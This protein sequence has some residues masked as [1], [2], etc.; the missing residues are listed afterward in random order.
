[1]TSISVTVR[2]IRRFRYKGVY[3]LNNRFGRVELTS[4]SVTVIVSVEG[5]DIKES[6]YIYILNIELLEWDPDFRFRHCDSVRDLFYSCTVFKLCCYTSHL[7]YVLRLEENVSRAMG[8]NV[9]T[10]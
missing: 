3:I 4:V 6:I 8:Q 5:L 2:V 9:L 1:M 7:K 10:P